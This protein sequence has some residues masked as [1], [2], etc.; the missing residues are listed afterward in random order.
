MTAVNAHCGKQLPGIA[1]FRVL[2]TNIQ[3]QPTANDQ[4][5]DMRFQPLLEFPDPRPRDFGIT[6]QSLALLVQERGL[7]E[8]FVVH[9]NGETMW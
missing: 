8:M 4:S 9:P 3:R 7:L 1:F 5:V 6:E 2:L